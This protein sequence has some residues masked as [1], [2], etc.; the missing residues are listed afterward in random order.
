MDSS[1]FEIK[2]DLVTTK[3]L[4][5]TIIS[6]ALYE[7]PDGAPYHFENDF[8]GNPRNEKNPLPGPIEVLKEGIN[9]FK[10]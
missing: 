2:T 5:V 1:I 3:R 8:F 4:G 9:A 6:E 7:E 10:F